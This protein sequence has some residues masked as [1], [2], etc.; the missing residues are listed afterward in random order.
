MYTSAGQQQDLN[1]LWQ[2]VQELSNVLAHN[3]EV[4]AG[5]ARSG[6]ELHHRV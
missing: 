4:T 5:V 3:R 6:E 1:H 2:Q